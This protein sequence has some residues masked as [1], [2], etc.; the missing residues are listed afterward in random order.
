VQFVF[1]I[2]EGGVEVEECKPVNRA[3]FTTAETAAPQG[4]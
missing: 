4:G 2:I 3:T 1:E